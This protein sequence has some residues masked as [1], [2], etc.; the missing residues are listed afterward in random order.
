MEKIELRDVSIPS[1]KKEETF[2]LDK[3]CKILD[4]KDFSIW[5]FYT[6]WTNN[7]VFR[8]YRKRSCR[9]VFL[10]VKLSIRKK[11]LNDLDTHIIIHIV[12]FL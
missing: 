2:V 11:K 9:P 3:F 12:T 10:V 5:K 6:K 7:H 4:L 8:S 1:M